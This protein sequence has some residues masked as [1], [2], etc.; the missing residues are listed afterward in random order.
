MLNDEDFVNLT[1]LTAPGAFDVF[2]G[3]PLKG[4]YV[5]LKPDTDELTTTVWHPDG[6]CWS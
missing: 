6:P 1:D 5:P 4:A 2:L 3:V